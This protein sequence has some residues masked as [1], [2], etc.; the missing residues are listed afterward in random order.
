MTPM[1]TR[2]QAFTLIELMVV[3]AL[4]AILMGL[5]M[6]GLARAKLKAQ[7]SRA[8]VDMKAMEQAIR[9]YRL[10]YSLWPGGDDNGLPQTTTWTVN[11]QDLVKYLM[12]SNPVPPYN[13]LNKRQRVFWEKQGSSLQFLDSWGSPYSVTIDVSNNL[14]RIISAGPDKNMATADDLTY[15]GR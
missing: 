2:L 13:V 10:E 14:V 3:M 5:V 7:I 11:N 9:N 4:I 6:S 15:E 12:S 1:K 8:Q